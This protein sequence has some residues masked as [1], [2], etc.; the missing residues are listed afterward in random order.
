[1]WSR[2]I[3]LKS[4]IWHF[5]FSIWLK[6][7]FGE[8]HF[9][10]NPT[11]IR[12]PRASSSK[13]MSNGRVLKTIENKRNPFLFSGCIS[14]SMLPTSDWIPLDFMIVLLNEQDSVVNIAVSNDS[15]INCLP[16]HDQ[17]SCSYSPSSYWF[18]EYLH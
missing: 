6:C 5:Q 7:S 12:P 8:V 17:T 3:S 11:W 15:H 14:Q 13:V 1:M 10:Y 18:V 16:I 2:E 4:N 9:V